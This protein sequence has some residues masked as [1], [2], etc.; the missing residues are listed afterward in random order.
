M[1]TFDPK[2]SLNFQNQKFKQLY[3]VHQKHPGQ[4]KIAQKEI[5]FFLFL[6]SI[7]FYKL[8]DYFY[9][10]FSLSHLKLLIRVQSSTFQILYYIF[11]YLF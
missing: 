5:L 2:N 8:A 3:F 6:V 7:R 9:N 11:Q 1:T 4:K 10:S